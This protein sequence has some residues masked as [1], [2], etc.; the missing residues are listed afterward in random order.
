M[1]THPHTPPHRLPITTAADSSEA[2][3]NGITGRSVLA[4][5]GLWLGMS[6]AVATASWYLSS[7][8]G[9]SPSTQTVTVLLVFEVYLLFPIAALIVYRPSGL[10]DRIKLRYTAGRDF[11]LALLVWVAILAAGTLTYACIGLMAGSIW[12]PALEVVRNAT[13][14]ARF[15]TATPLDWVLILPRALLLAGVTEELLFRGV[16]YGWLRR[17]LRPWATILITTALFTVEHYFLVIFPLAIIYGLLVGWLREKTG[18]VLPGL[19]VHILTDTLL[20]V[21]ALALLAHGIPA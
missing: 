20:F 4:V 12:A 18:S 1:S 19:L 21:I 16:L 7:V 9:T 13:D 8:L 6:A 10:R 17:H 11:G 15:P 14:M 2:N 3:T 5:I